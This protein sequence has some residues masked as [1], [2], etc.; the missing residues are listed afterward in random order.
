QGN[1]EEARAVLDRV[2]EAEPGHL[3]TLLVA[4]ELA[5]AAGDHIRA[6]A[7][8]QQAIDHN[9]TAVQPRVL[10]GNHYITIDRPGEALAVAE[11]LLGANPNHLGLLET[12]GQARLRTGDRTGALKV[13]E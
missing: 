8:W 3:E 13:F 7:L 4:A 5:S 11:P 6:E 12:V 10:L 2:L 9:R 1:I